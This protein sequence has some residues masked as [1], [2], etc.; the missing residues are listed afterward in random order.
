MLRS[1]ELVNPSAPSRNHTNTIDWASPWLDV[2]PVKEARGDPDRKQ[3]WSEKQKYRFCSLWYHSHF[4]RWLH[5]AHVT[6]SLPFVSQSRPTSYRKEKVTLFQGEWLKCLR[7]V[8][9]LGLCVLVLLWDGLFISQVKS[10]RGRQ[11]TPFSICTAASATHHF[12]LR[13]KY[14]LAGQG[15]LKWSIEMDRKGQGTFALTPN[16]LFWCRFE[17]FP[18]LP[19][20]W[21]RW[22]TL[23]GVGGFNSYDL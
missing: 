12:L 3:Q 2:R 23:E 15:T 1:E 18:V 21:I 10:S 16:G 9:G 4:V 19:W 22:F 17:W 8:P 11:W 7:R 14:H 5:K 13:Y 6:H 20:V